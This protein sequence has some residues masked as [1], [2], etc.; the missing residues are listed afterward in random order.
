MSKFT[1]VKNLLFFRIH[2]RRH[3]ILFRMATG[4]MIVRN[5]PNGSTWSPE[6]G[7]ANPFAEDNYPFQAIDAKSGFLSSV[8][9]RDI[10]Y[11]CTGFDEGFKMVFTMPG[12]TI[13]MSQNYLRLPLSEYSMIYV[14]FELT[15]TSDRLRQYKLSQRQCFFQSERQ[16]R[17][18]K[19]YTQTNCEEECL[20]NFTKN[21]CGCVKFSMPSM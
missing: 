18:F 12:E 2:N 1:L 21:E 4:M 11:R 8:Y 3:L 13:K 14:T 20:A 16:L 5:N 7:Y 15:K 19:I 17:F 6:N 9:R 10:E